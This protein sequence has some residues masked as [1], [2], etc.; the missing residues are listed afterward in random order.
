VA[1]FWALLA[2]GCSAL[3]ERT[4]LVASA[5]A[6]ISRVAL[7]LED[8]SLGA[9]EHPRLI[10]GFGGVY[11]HAKLESILNAV[12][13]DLVPA[14]DRPDLRYQVTILNSPSVNAFALPGG[15]LYVT[16][17]LLALAND[18]SEL[19]A[20]LAHEMAHVT[21]RHAAQ[22]DERAKSAVLASQVVAELQHDRRAGDVA[23]QRS[24]VTLAGFSRQQELEADAAGIATTARAGYDPGGA[25][26][27]LVSLSR[28]TEAENQDRPGA[29]GDGDLQSSHPTTPARVER[30]AALAR[31]TPRSPS[32][33]PRG[34]REAYLEALNGL[35]YG[36]R[37]QEGLVRGRRFIHTELGFTFDA[38]EGFTLENSPRAVFG[39]GQNGEAMR[40]D[41]A[42]MPGSGPPIELVTNGWIEGAE[43]RDVR[44][45]IVDGLPAAIG[46]A[47]IGEWTFRVGAIRQADMIYR[48]AIGSKTFSPELDGVFL[49]TIRSFRRTGPPETSTEAPLRLQVVRV[50]PGDTPA[51]LARRMRTE[52]DKLE[53]FLI[54]NGL[55]AGAALQ[56]GSLVKIVAEGA[57]EG[58]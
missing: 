22:R 34:N 36:D 39:V 9:R 44:P 13:A 37:S 55:K 32:A 38:P 35:L 33:L 15:Y 58:A 20:V 25:A 8:A 47:T 1:L 46:L 5:P 50:G 45:I 21:A 57:P 31:S 7:D 48:F 2:A 29:P 54:L 11:R 17:G 49:Q 28:Q 27:F 6:A 52:G 19:A 24:Q 14:T 18:H 56:P 53:R 41:G 51:S 26:R 10:E 4:A 40:F 30:A 3:G 23:L 43:I 12:V 16:R 42:K